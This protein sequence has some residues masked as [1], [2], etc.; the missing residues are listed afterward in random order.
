MYKEFRDTTLTGAVKKMYSEMASRHRARKA[1]IHVIRT[2]VVK[3]SEV[4]R[5]NTQ[6]FINS[7]IRFRLLHRVPRASDKSHKAIFKHKTPTTF[8]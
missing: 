7:N 5:P 1:S 6:Q 4:K 8:F 2:A 3:A